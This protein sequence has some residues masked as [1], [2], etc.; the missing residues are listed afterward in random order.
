VDGNLIIDNPT[1]HGNINWFG[2]ALFCI[3]CGL[4]VW[5]FYKQGQ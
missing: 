2:L 5:V 3:A 4:C 1:L